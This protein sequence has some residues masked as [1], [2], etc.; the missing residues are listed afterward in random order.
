MEKR[1]SREEFSRGLEIIASTAKTYDLILGSRALDLSRGIAR[2]SFEKDVEVGG[3]RQMRSPTFEFSREYIEDVPGFPQ[4]RTALATFLESLSLRLAHPRP[5]QFMTLSGVPIDLEIH[6]PFREVQTSHDFFVH[7]LV[8]VGSPWS[9]EA[10]LSVVLA[11][12]DKFDVGPSLTPPTVEALVV[13]A[14]RFAIDSNKVDFYRVGHHPASLQEV[15][16]ISSEPVHAA[17]DQ[18]VKEYFRRKAYW[19]GFREGDERSGIAII[20]PYDML[21]LRRTHQQLR[22]LAVVMEAT[23]ELKIDAMKKFAYANTSLLQQSDV[24]EK[25]LSAALA[26]RSQAEDT[27]QNSSPNRLR[28][29]IPTVFISY[30]TEDSHF[31]RSLSRALKERSIGVWFDD[32]EIRVGDSLTNRIGEALHAYDFI[33]VVLSPASVKSRW[34]QKELAEAMMREIKQKKVVVLP[35]IYRQCEIPPFLTDQRYADFTGDSDSAL[36]LLV[37][38]IER[39]HVSPQFEI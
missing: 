4:Y 1:M 33:I 13:N 6:W 37:N 34:V 25:E 9:H 7:V 38:S 16:I 22:Q 39:H 3:R 19:L 28:N 35:V 30:S 20:D 29:T 26:R 11:G 31:A 24:L 23:G 5:Q 17:N 21:Y 27:A 18:K 14:I 12:I 10:N 36:N 32:Q 8:R 2:L 15:P